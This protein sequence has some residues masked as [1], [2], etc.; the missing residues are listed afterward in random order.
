MRQAGVIAGAG[1]YALEHNVQRLAED[2][3]NARVLA[4]GLANI[5]GIKIDPN[6]VSTNI[7]FFDVRS[8][9]RIFTRNHRFC[10]L[11]GHKHD[12]CSFHCE[13][14]RGGSFHGRYEQSM[15]RDQPIA[16]TLV[17]QIIRI[18]WFEQ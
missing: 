4:Q 2:H 18:S 3:E 7:V 11:P 9:L 6:A 17:C 8:S 1:L 14:S 16:M 10:C 5:S 13:T 12:C 15:P